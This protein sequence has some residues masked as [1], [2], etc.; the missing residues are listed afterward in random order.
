MLKFHRQEVT[1]WEDYEFN[2]LDADEW[3]TTQK[4]VIWIGSQKVGNVQMQ[5][6]NISEIN[7]QDCIGDN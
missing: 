6:K 2:G 7:L 4:S 1:G 5:K 3:G